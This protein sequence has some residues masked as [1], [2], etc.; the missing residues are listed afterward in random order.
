MLDGN[1]IL[2]EYACIFSNLLT[3]KKNIE[4]RGDIYDGNPE[5]Q[6]NYFIAISD[7]K[8]TKTKA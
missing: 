4:A 2:I 8:K 5:R 7:Q 1:Y 3:K 6:P